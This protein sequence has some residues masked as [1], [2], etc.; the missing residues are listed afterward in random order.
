MRAPQL[1][2]YLPPG[3]VASPQLP[4]VFTFSWDAP[5]VGIKGVSHFAQRF[6]PA[7]F[8]FPQFAQKAIII[9]LCPAFAW[10]VFKFEFPEFPFPRI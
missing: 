3:V 10:R 2:Q 6:V 5:S 8:S 9:L 1:G 4:H 7:S